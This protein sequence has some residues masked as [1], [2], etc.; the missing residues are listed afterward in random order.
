MPLFAEGFVRSRIARGWGPAKV[1]VGLAKSRIASGMAREALAAGFPREV[2]EERAL[3]VL[4]GHRVR[5]RG[6]RTE[7][8][9]RR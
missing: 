9:P 1:R 2:E 8:D 4:R 5:F 3:P 6:G 7:E